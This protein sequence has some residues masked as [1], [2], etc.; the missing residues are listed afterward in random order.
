[1]DRSADHTGNSLL[2]GWFLAEWFVVM[3][4]SYLKIEIQDAIIRPILSAYYERLEGCDVWIEWD[5]CPEV[6]VKLVLA[7][8][9]AVRYG[10]GVAAYCSPVSLSWYG[11]FVFPYN[12]NE[13]TSWN[14]P[15]PS[16]SQCHGRNKTPRELFLSYHTF[17]CYHVLLAWYPKKVK[18]RTFALTGVSESILW[19]ADGQ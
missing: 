5:V 18:I 2:T 19:T 6:R 13:I 1:M 3:V 14:N 15:R 17:T 7:L 4:Q 11:N 12:R 10:H 16:H 9:Q 8:E